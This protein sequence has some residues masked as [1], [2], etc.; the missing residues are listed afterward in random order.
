M[1][2]Y[3]RAFL[4]T[5]LMLPMPLI[6]QYI[7]IQFEK[8]TGSYPHGFTALSIA[9]SIGLL[10]LNVALWISAIKDKDLKDL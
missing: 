9:V 6:I 5:A 3:I 10:V 4:S 2:R 1:K 7:S 8:Q